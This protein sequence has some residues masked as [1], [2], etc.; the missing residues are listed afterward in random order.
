MRNDAET[1]Q[2]ERLDL[3]RKHAGL[4]LDNGRAYRC[5]CPPQPADPEAGWTNGY[6]GTCKHIPRAESD[7]RA[8]IGEPHVIRFDPSKEP[9]EYMDIVYGQRNTQSSDNGPVIIKSDGFPTYHFANVVDDHHME[10]THVIR[11][12]VRCLHVLSH[13][14]K[15]NRA[16]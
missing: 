9:I 11:G 2:S 8:A 14:S 10:I 1:L 3:Y 13:S 16:N 12:A 6:P 5:F 4:L 7:R 15:Q